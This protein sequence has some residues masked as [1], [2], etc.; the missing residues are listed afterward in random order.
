MHLQCNPPEW[1]SLF[2]FHLPVVSSFPSSI[3][4]STLWLAAPRCNQLM[5]QKNPTVFSHPN[6]NTPLDAEADFFFPRDKIRVALL[7]KREICFYIAF[8][9]PAVDKR[10]EG[11]KRQDVFRGFTSSLVMWLYVSQKERGS[12]LQHNDTIQMKF[13]ITSSAVMNR[14]EGEQM[15]T[16]FKA[17][18]T[19]AFWVNVR[20]FCFCIFGLDC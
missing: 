5:L 15:Y 3:C 16:Y 10:L 4:L 20:K 7:R 12:G 8:I 6:K 1:Q 17:R 14:A 19:G 11:C 2:L 18:I 13:E 9:F